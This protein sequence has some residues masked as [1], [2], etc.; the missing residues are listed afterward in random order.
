MMLLSFCTPREAKESNKENE[1]TLSSP[2]AFHPVASCF[3][4]REALAVL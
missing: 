1:Q 4:P 3:A 2:F